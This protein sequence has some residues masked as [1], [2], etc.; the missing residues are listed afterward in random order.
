VAYAGSLVRRLILGRGINLP[1]LL[2]V[3]CCVPLTWIVI[4][5]CVHSDIPGAHFVLVPVLTTYHNLQYHG[6]IWHYNR[7][8]YHP[9]ASDPEARRRLG[10]A[11]TL[12]RNFGT[13]LLWGLVYTAG[14]IGFEHYGIGTLLAQDTVGMLSRALF[15]GFAFHHYYL[16]S[17][18]WHASEDAELRAVL[19]FPGR[20]A[21]PGPVAAVP[22]TVPAESPPGVLAERSG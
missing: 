19:G 1:L 13:Y 7:R 20:Q 14:T 16:D 18:I 21:V 4:T 12:N 22:A 3:L 11:V 8:R 15:W 5:G 10:L 9:S 2:L 6:L 17:K